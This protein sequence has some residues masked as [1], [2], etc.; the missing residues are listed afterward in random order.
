MKRAALIVVAALVVIA[1]LLGLRRALHREALAVLAPSADGAREGSWQFPRGGPYILG[2]E[3]PGPAR[4]LI[5]GRP[6]VSGAGEREGE[7]DAPGDQRVGAVRA[8]AGGEAGAIGGIGGDRRG[9]DVFERAAAARGMP[10]EAR[11]RG[12]LEADGVH[13]R[14]VDHALD[15]LAVAL[16]VGIPRPDPTWALPAAI[17]AIALIVRLSGLGAA[18]QTWDEDEYWCAG[19]NYLQ[20]ILALDFSPHA[21]RW[22]YEHPPV[23]KYLAGLG[24]LWADGYGPA[25]GL[26]A[27]VG[28]LGACFVALIGRRL[29]G[30]RVGALAGIGAALLPR[31]IAH[32]QIVGHETPSFLWW[33]LGVWL[34]LRVGGSSGS[35]RRGAEGPLIEED[36]LAATARRLAGVGV[37][38]GVAVA[39]R[40]SN[41]LLGPVLGVAVLAGAPMGRHLRA[42]LVGLVATPLAA[43]LTFVAL[44]PRM[45]SAPKAHLDAAW[46]VLKRQHLPEHYLGHLIQQPPWHYFP[47]YLIVT[48]P[49]VV[50]AS[51][52]LLGAWRGAT[53]REPRLLVLVVWLLLPL[54]V[55]WSPV[56]QDGVR[57]VIPALAPLCLLAALGLDH[58]ATSFPRLRALPLAILLTYTAYL[59]VTWA[60]IRP[61]GLDYFGEHV[62]GPSTVARK[63]WFE[64]GWWGEGIAE[65]VEHVNHAA[66]PG[67]SVARILQPVHVNWLREDLWNDPGPARADWILVNDQGLMAVGQ[68]RDW[69]PPGAT[70]VY[71]ARAQGASLV[72]VYRR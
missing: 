21:W 30:A 43:L 8:G 52:L 45:W 47:L 1:A 9:G 24:A 23:T 58:L 28:A 53:R 63:E 2:F 68:R 66:A 59:G 26:F 57:Y 7:D 72:R 22:N 15:A 49:L 37:V 14:G 25:R 46:A 62:G 61:Y 5:D 10:E 34:A 55:I 19:R 40:F 38:L 41:L 31:L 13:T 35:A 29:G 44:W 65:A 60:R 12:A 3:A 50:I 69:A 17:F 56:R 67:A 32:D 4:L 71:E 42:T 18:G 51:A 20:N 39:T 6:V 70:L 64:I 36:T 48:T 11:V 33:S 27:A 54:G 16:L